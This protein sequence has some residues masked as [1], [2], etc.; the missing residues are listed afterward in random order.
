MSRSIR[1]SLIVGAILFIF[2]SQRFSVRVLWGG[3]L[4][5]VMS[6]LNLFI[7]SRISE[8]IFKPYQKKEVLFY[9]AFKLPIFYG[10]LVFLLYQFHFS[11]YAFMIGFSVPLFVIILKTYGGFVGERASIIRSA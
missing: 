11:L 3:S 1:T 6:V 9:I 4:G 5:I 8:I 7:L 2:L 10:L